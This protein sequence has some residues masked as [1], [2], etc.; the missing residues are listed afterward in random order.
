MC[1]W[2]FG[3]AASDDQAA[4]G[5]ESPMPDM[6]AAGWRQMKWLRSWLIAPLVGELALGRSIEREALLREQEALGRLADALAALAREREESER[7]RRELEH[8]KGRLRVT[9]G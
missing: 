9:H 1:R 7:L 8:V 3:G 4:Q 5:A 6:H 2:T